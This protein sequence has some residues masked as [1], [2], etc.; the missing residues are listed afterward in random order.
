M[1]EFSPTAIASRRSSGERAAA[2]ATAPHAGRSAAAIEGGGARA[3]YA[4]SPGQRS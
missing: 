2:I 3:P 1:E 4:M